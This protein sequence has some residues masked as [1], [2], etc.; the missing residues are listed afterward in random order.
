MFSLW[1]NLLSSLMRS[2]AIPFA[3]RIRYRRLAIVF[4]QRATAKPNTA[5]ER[6]FGISTRTRGEMM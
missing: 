6:A 2:G 3:A 1:S 5:V 4:K